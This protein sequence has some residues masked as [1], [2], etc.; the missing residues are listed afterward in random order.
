MSSSDWSAVREI[1]R[2][3]LPPLT[4]EQKEAARRLNLSE[5]EF[6]RRKLAD[7]RGLERLR[8]KIRRFA[9]FVKERL[10]AENPD[11]EIE[12]IMLDTLAGRFELE[13]KVN[14]ARV[15]VEV[16]EDLV[17]ELF[18]AGSAEAEQRL[19]RVVH[20]ALKFGP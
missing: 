11:A 4:P 12:Q 10:A 9:G 16:S 7:Q 17:D 19:G 6:A 2:E 13:L 20:L 1:P 5:E 8:A 15:P 14:G 3:A 18:H